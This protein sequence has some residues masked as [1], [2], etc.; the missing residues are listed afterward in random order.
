MTQMIIKLKQ[1]GK[2]KMKSY[3]S[4]LNELLEKHNI[5]QKQISQHIGVKQPTISRWLNGERKL[6]LTTLFII[7]EFVAMIAELDKNK[8]LKEILV[9]D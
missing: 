9:Y 7:V 5:T 3:L 8:I 4:A 1:I 6:P 2:L